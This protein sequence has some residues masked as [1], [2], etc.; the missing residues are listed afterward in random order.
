MKTFVLV[1]LWLTHVYLNANES[2][3]P[4]IQ[5]YLTRW[6]KNKMGAI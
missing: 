1:I 4:S 6:G 2:P 3:G 5:V